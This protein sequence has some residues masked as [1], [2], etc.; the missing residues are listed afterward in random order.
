MI[1]LKTLLNLLKLFFGKP[2]IKYQEFFETE[3]KSVWYIRKK[4]TLQKSVLL[5]F[6]SKMSC[7]YLLV[8]YSRHVYFNTTCSVHIV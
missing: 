5:I 3:F 1:N 7:D 2:E 6:I 4:I 8:L